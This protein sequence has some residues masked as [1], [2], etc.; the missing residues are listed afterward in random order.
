MTPFSHS[1]VVAQTV[2][3]WTER[4]RPNSLDQMEG[5]EAPM[6]K[7]RQWLDRW[8]KGTPPKRGLLL[9]GPPGVGK[10]TLARAVSSERGW[11]VIELNASAD[12]NAASIRS[13]ATHG[14]QHISLDSFVNGGNS[15]SKTL[16]LLD[17]VDHLG[18]GF[19]RVSDERIESSLEPSE[20]ST[21]LK[22]DTGGKAELLN[23]LE[24]TQQPIIMTCN[25]PM[26][27]WGRNSSWK[28][29]RDR[30]LSKAEMI[31]FNRVGKVH[32]R[33]VAHRVLDAENRSID[34]GALESLI[35]DNPGDL[36]ALVRDLQ[37]ICAIEEG[38][39][40]IEAVSSLTVV[41]VSDAL[42][43]IFE[44]MREV[45]KSKSG[46]RLFGSDVFRQGSR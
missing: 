22:G 42:G 4:Y 44:A 26:K 41:A 37:A 7:I 3:D 20:D 45:Y 46:K 12:R 10:T 25:E 24:N 38:H 33:R 2:D 5:N 13:A 31:S 36:R 19:A 35:E 29:N 21:V 6:R 11:T 27:L 17:E 32:L 30:L 28:R 16:I 43:A 18:G 23:L 34:P 9:S 39:I 15:N 1:I 14:S 8:E 40:D